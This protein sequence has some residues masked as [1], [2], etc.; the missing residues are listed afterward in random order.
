MSN[1]VNTTDLNEK[2][3]WL[4]AEFAMGVLD[5]DEH[6]QATMLYDQNVSF[7]HEVDGWTSRLTPMLDDV[8]PQMPSPAVWSQ[9]ENRLGLV[10]TP[11]QTKGFAAWWQSVNLW[12]SLSFGTS[13]LAAI[14]LALLIYGNPLTTPQTAPVTQDLVATLTAE[15]A[16]PA[17][18]ARL[19]REK[20]RM[21]VLTN[22]QASA[23][24]DHELW[25]VPAEGN[26]ISLALVEAQGSADLQI[27]QAILDQ[28]G[29]G[30]TF[31]ISVEPLGGSPTGLPTGPVIATGQLRT[32]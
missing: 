31:A 9:I 25:L 19:N 14:A 22:M 6:A 24:H 20:G 27:D 29:E 32:I 16:G 23:E 4:A 12:R 17:M 18:V 30:A 26:P 21:T 2:E 3:R 8:E 10:E 7:R 11:A 1:S 15:G 5:K 13:A 28:L